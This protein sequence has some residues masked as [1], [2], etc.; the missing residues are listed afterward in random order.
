M[1]ICS[2]AAPTFELYLDVPSKQHLSVAKA[3]TGGAG[4]SPRRAQRAWARCTSD[5][6]PIQ[7]SAPRVSLSPML[8]LDGPRALAEFVHRQP[9]CCRPLQAE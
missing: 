3:L 5:G 2:Q 8:A 1:S 7:E 6:E 4:W 9:V